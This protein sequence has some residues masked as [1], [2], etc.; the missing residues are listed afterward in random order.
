MADE[1]KAVYPGAIVKVGG[2]DHVDYR[3]VPQW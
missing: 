1:V 2:F 3:R